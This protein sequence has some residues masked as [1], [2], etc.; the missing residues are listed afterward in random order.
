MSKKKKIGVRTLLNFQWVMEISN[1]K[2]NID[3]L[4]TMVHIYIYIDMSGIRE[5]TFLHGC[6]SADQSTWTWWA[7]RRRSV[8]RVTGAG[9]WYS[10]KS[11]S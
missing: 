4:P 2:L 8:V 7:E 3:S 10:A 1:S 5:K 11:K 6:L 9:S